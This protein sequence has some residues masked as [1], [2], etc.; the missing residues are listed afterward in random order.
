MYTCMCKF[1]SNLFFKNVFYKIDFSWHLENWVVLVWLGMH[2]LSQTKDYI[3][4]SYIV[5]KNFRD[6][7]GLPIWSKQMLVVEFVTE[8]IVG[9]LWLKQWQKLM[10]LDILVLGSSPCVYTWYI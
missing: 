8:E 2:G 7:F 4:L 3:M 1:L 5:R 9:S 10:V 6:N